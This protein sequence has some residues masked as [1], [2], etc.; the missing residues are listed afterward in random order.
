M[1]KITQAL[2]KAARE[3][4]QR[5]AV[6]AAKPGD[7]PKP[8]SVP[9][10]A[11]IEL[12]RAAPS[13]RLTIDPHIVAVAA[14]ESPIAEQYRIL[15]TGIQSLRLRQ[16][17]NVLMVTSAVAGEGKS[18]T[19]ANLALSLASQGNARI[20]LVDGDLRRS[21]IPRWLGLPDRHLGLSTI[22]QDSGDARE[23]LYRLESP[24]L[25]VL[26]A[27]PETDQ[28]AELL[29][30]AAFKRV[31]ATLRTQF[32]LIILDAPPVLPVADPSI[33]A[34]HVDGILMVVRAG[35]TQRR[36]VQQA[37]QALKKVKANILG[38]VLTHGEQYWAGYARYY[39]QYYRQQNNAQR[40]A[41]DAETVDGAGQHAE[42]PD[43]PTH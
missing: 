31:L 14:P 18:V 7:E 24:P 43:E 42:P 8:V 9:F 20:A 6:A 15:R 22:L 37:L 13:G 19:A 41:K 3:R 23:A 16:G 5:S 12:E 2:E 1:S 11:A 40:A 35:R 21:S 26:P 10:V 25:T 39:R 36:T 38:C 29:E 34:A 4:L 30:S 17:S 33:M 27:G 28:P 32:D